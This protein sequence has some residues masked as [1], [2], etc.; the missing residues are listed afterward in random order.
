MNS[1]SD[2]AGYVIVHDL[3]SEK[4]V[5]KAELLVQKMEVLYND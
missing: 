5:E 2:R 1:N 4:A 3:I